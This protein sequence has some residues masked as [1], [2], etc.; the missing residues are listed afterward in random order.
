MESL[1]A[2]GRI[3]EAIA[4]LMLVEFVLIL[5]L[6]RRLGRGPSAGAL[7]ATLL[8]G[9]CL[10]MALR[11]ALVGAGMAAIGMWLAAALVAHVADMLL[12]FRR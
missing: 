9:L 2:S 6:R 7:A 3:A 11:E 8:A 10:V 1:F 12:R 4:V 5:A